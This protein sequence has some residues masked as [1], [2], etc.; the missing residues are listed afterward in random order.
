MKKLMGDQ[1]R[2]KENLYAYIQDF[3]LAVRDIFRTG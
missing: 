3:S 2:N 1:D